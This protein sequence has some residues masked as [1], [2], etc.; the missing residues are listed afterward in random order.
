MLTGLVLLLLMD[1]WCRPI[2]GS[3]LSAPTRSTLTLFPRKHHPREPERE[4]GTLRECILLCCQSA[5][6]KESMDGVMEGWRSGGRGEGE[7]DRKDGGM[8]CKGGTSH[9]RGVNFNQT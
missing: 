4:G 2:K 7:K 1:E 5:R 3:H 6:R 8:W 9:L